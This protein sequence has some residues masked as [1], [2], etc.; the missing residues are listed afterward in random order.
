M[1]LNILFITNALTSELKWALKIQGRG[2]GSRE[3]RLRATYQEPRPRAKVKLV[4]ANERPHERC[5]VRRDPS[6]GHPPGDKCITSAL[7]T[8]LPP[9]DPGQGT[10][11]TTFLAQVGREPSW[12]SQGRW[13]RLGLL[14]TS[15]L[16]QGDQ[17][18]KCPKH[19]CTRRP[20]DHGPVSLSPSI[21][22]H[23]AC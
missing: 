17:V 19:H 13:R 20:Q 12:R 11:V 4:L 21:R 23:V 14:T 7:L 10:G 1:V 9:R 22:H 6:Q 18:L 5:R 8:C 15:S 2:W 3:T 16:P